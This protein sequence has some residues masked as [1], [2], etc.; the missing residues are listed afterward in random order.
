MDTKNNF[1][2]DDGMHLPYERV[3]EKLQQHGGSLH[4]H[5]EFNKSVSRGS[6]V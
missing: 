2:W 3:V 4:A 5:I 1:S 6:S